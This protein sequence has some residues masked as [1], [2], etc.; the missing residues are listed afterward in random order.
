MPPCG[1]PSR[2]ATDLAEIWSRRLAAL[3][4]WNPLLHQAVIVGFNRNTDLVRRLGAGEVPRLLG[5]LP[6]E[7]ARLLEADLAGSRSV[8]RHVGPDLEPTLQALGPFEAAVGGQ[9]GIVGE[10]VRTLGGRPIDLTGQPRD[11]PHYVFEF[12]EAPG[13]SAG[14]I[15]L[16]ASQGLEPPPLTAISEALAAGADSAFV[17]GFHLMDPAVIRRCGRHLLRLRSADVP[18]HIELGASGPAVLDALRTLLPLAD[19]VGANEAEA[20][21]LVGVAGGALR[22]LLD[23]LREFVRQNL[24]ARLHVHLDGMQLALTEAPRTEEPRG[25]LLAGAAAAEVAGTGR[26]APSLRET[27]GF[28]AGDIE[29]FARAIDSLGG[30]PATG[31]VGKDAILVPSALVP[32]PRRV[33]GLGDVLSSVAFLARARHIKGRA[34]DSESE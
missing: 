10:V 30:D 20:R 19:S 14:R 28:P 26:V 17:S 5:S 13:R 2:V 23:P 27:G 12:G 11:V 6:A 4:G 18:V 3:R 8:E 22:D 16:S 25:L 9:A 21:H 29:R 15:I 34:G 33:V 1:G 31:Q 7:I 24:V 32:S